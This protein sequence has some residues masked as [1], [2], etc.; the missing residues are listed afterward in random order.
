M[1]LTNAERV[2]VPERSL[3]PLLAAQCRAF[4]PLRRELA[5]RR[6]QEA[7]GGE[8]GRGAVTQEPGHGVQVGGC[9]RDPASRSC[10]ALEGGLEG[11]S[12]EVIPTTIHLVLCLRINTT[13]LAFLMYCCVLHA[14]LSCFVKTSM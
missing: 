10:Q 3:N 5:S 4:D 12:S 6:A 2:R 11:A 9:A 13:P 1:N 8:E 14:P 7:G